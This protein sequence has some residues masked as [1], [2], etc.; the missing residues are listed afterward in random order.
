[1]AM[2]PLFGREHPVAAKCL[3]FLRQSQR[4]DGA[5]PIDTNLSVWLTTGRARD[6]AGIAD[7]SRQRRDCPRID[8]DQTARWIA[9]AQYKVRHR[10]TN[11]EPGGWA[12]THL[13]GGVPDVD[14]TS[15]AILALKALR[16]RTTASPTACGGC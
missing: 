9:A 13:A 6:A 11:A 14:D 1:M 5:W 4:S 15:G 16:Q 8:R 7:V 3:G 10:Y 2:M 12:W